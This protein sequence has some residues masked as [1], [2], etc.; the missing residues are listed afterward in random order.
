MGNTYLC[1]SWGHL[2]PKSQTR[3]PRVRWRASKDFLG[4]PKLEAKLD[5]KRTR[6]GPNGLQVVDFVDLC[7]LVC[8]H[9]GP[10]THESPIRGPFEPKIFQNVPNIIGPRATKSYPASRGAV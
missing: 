1:W 9:V 3:P 4:T 10:R 8:V 5:P 6:L 7:L 2:G